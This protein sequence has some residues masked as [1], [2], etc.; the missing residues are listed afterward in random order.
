MH[1]HLCHLTRV[2]ERDMVDQSSFLSSQRLFESRTYV[3]RVYVLSSREVDV[4]FAR[5]T[6]NFNIWGRGWGS[7]RTSFPGWARGSDGTDGNYRHRL[8]VH[9]PA[10]PVGMGTGKASTRP[11]I[12]ARGSKTAHYE[13]RNAG[14][15]ITALLG[16]PWD[17]KPRYSSQCSIFPFHPSRSA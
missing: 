7:A 13:C 1:H 2:I 11:R 9:G 8:T 14:F 16:T 5:P 3:S 12:R 6:E 4:G 15:L 10:G 17:I